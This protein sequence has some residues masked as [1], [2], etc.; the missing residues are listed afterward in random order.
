[1]AWFDKE[2]EAKLPERL[3]GKTPEQVL[4]ELEKADKL[5]NDLELEKAARR[6]DAEKVTQIETE[7][8][9][10]KNQLATIEANRNTK[11][12]EKT[13][14]SAEQILENPDAAITTKVNELT[15]P[16][17]HLTI[18]NNAQT[19]RMLAQQQL[20]NTD[21]ASG[22][23]SMDGR[24]FQAW[25]QEIDAEA[26][27]YKPI[28]LITPQAWLGI[29]YYLKGTHADELRDPETRK[30]KYNFLE[31]TSS[32]I[33]PASREEKKTGAE[34]LTDEE[35][36]IAGRMGVTPEAYAKRKEAMQ[37]VNG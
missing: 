30:K 14:V 15:A 12:P 17:T 8:N 33:A 7:F 22:G 1:M 29:F 35:K 24:L 31:P 19:A 37:Y 5:A 27:K 36:R 9:T 10:V 28:Q 25:S 26:G 21:L 23:K 13:V 20:N 16:L 4:A 3:K 18:Q 32:G 2:Q 6:A 11:P 34:G